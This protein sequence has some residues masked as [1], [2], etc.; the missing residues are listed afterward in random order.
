MEKS[1]KE[2]VRG[3]IKG[4]YRLIFK[5]FTRILHAEIRAYMCV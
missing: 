3:R 2:Q 4:N 5:Y 1:K